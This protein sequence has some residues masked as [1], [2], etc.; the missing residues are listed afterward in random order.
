MVLRHRGRRA[1]GLAERS[2]FIADALGLR[3]P[4]EGG[5]EAELST[6]MSWVLWGAYFLPGAVA[7]CVG[8]LDRD[9]AGQCRAGMALPWIQPPFRPDGRVVHAGRRQG[10]A[11]QRARSD[12]LR[13]LLGLTYWQFVRTPTGFIPQQDKGYLLLNVQLPDSAS[14][15]RTQ[16]M[17]ARI[18][19]LAHETPGVKHTLGVS[20]QSLL[21][22]AN[23][24]NLGSLYIMLDEFSKRRGTKLTADAIAADIQDAA[25]RGCAVPS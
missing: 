13:G 6:W 2:S 25:S 24:P 10:V 22:N 19:T 18:E 15:E 17:M 3:V 5:P 8:R 16:R 23:A 20:G 21:L 14:V 1:Y 7:G 12:C 11:D 9:P 4:A